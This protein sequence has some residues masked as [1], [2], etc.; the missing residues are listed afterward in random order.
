MTLSTTEV[1]SLRSPSHGHT[2]NEYTQE[3][4]GVE[5]RFEPIRATSES[6]LHRG[7]S[8]VNL[9]WFVLEDDGFAPRH[10]V[11]LVSELFRFL[12]SRTQKQCS[13]DYDDQDQ[14]SKSHEK[15]RG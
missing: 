8:D 13:Y 14:Y 1:G 12:L 11:V 9:R 15:R 4:L 3:G 2:G 6:T 10:V 7:H 5:L